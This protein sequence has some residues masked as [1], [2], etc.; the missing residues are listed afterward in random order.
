MGNRTINTY[1]YIFVTAIIASVFYIIIINRLSTKKTQ[2]EEIATIFHSE[3]KINAV[4][5]NNIIPTSIDEIVIGNDGYVYIS[6]GV[7][8]SKDWVKIKQ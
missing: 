2:I 8:S 1:N 6:E 5:I 3:I 4:D 7:N